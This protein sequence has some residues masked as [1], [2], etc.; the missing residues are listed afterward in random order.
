MTLWE[1]FRFE[2]AYQSRRAWTW[3]YFAVPLVVN[4]L[5]T[6]NAYGS[7]GG[8]YVLNSPLLI[9][10]FTLIA[11]VTGLLAT[12]AVA[13]E[14][15]ARD[16]QVRMYAFVYTSPVGKTSYL[17]G[18]FLAAFVPNALLMLAVQVVHLLSTVA[19]TAPQELIGPFKLIGY[20]GAYLLIGLPNAFIAT[21]LLFSLAVLSR[22][23][24]ASFVGVALLL[25]AAVI[26]YQLM[27][28]GRP[29][30]AQA[31]DPL[32]AVLFARIL[33]TIADSQSDTFSVVSY[34]PLLL[35]RLVWLGAALAVLVFTHSRFRFEHVA[36]RTW[37]RRRITDPT[38][39]AG[40]ASNL[41]RVN[42]SHSRTG[43]RRQALV[44]ADAAQDLGSKRPPHIHVRQT[45]A[46][47]IRSYRQ[48]ANSWGGLAL[49]VLAT[50]VIFFESPTLNFLVGV[51][52][53]PTTEL[54]AAAVGATG[55]AV[56]LLVRMF[57]LFHVGELIWRERETR[58]NDIADA[59][60]TPEG[61]RV[62][63]RLAGLVLVFLTFQALMLVVCVFNQAQFGYR[64]FELGLYLRILFGFQFVDYFLFLML[65]F[66]VHVVVNQK[67]FAY[68]VVVLLSAFQWMFRIYGVLL[69]IE[70]KMLVYGASPP[71]LYSDIRA[72]E[73]TVTPWMW[74]SLYW[75]GWAFLFG[76]IST[77]FWIRGRETNIL[78]RL[79]LAR[80]R[81]T[82]PILG[83]TTTAAALIFTAGGFIFYNT[84]L[85]NADASV[86]ARARQ[87]AEY[88]R[89]YGQYAQ[90]PQPQLEGM[91]LGVEIYPDRNE[92]EIRGTYRLVN[93]S[94]VA[95]DSIQVAPRFDVETS[96]ASFDRPADLILDD[97]KLS[98]RIYA[99]KT[100]LAPGEATQ[101]DFTVRF[102]PR[103]FTNEGIDPSVAANGTYFTGT[104]WLPGV[105]YQHIR[106]LADPADRRI[107]DLPPRPM[108]PSPEDAST[109][110]N[111]TENVSLSLETIVGTSQGQVAV[112]PGALLK[113]WTESGRR[114]FQYITDVP[115]R[116]DFAIY[117]AAYVVRDARWKDVLI[118]ILHHP[119]H[120]ANVERMVRG[121]QASLE[122]L[123]RTF[124]PYPHRQIRFV[125][126]PGDGDSLHSSPVNI[127][128]EEGFTRFRPESDPQD[129]S[130]PFAVVAHEVAH[131]WWGNQL[132]PARAE[133]SALLTESIAWYCA[134]R[135][136][137]EQF[138]H[139][140]LNRLLDAMRRA[141]L[142]WVIPGAPPL[143]RASDG[144]HAYRK[145]PF[146][147]YALD[148]YIGVDR[149]DAAIS[150]L[151]QKYGSGQTP[152]PTSLDLYAEFK[153]VTPDEH[154]KLL[155]DLFETNT[156][157]DLETKRATAKQTE[158]GAW[159]V[160]LDVRAHKAEVAIDGVAT[161]IPMDDM[162]EVGVFSA[163]PKNGGRGEPL[164]LR[165]H[166]IRS[167]QQDITVTVP[168]EPALA[169][170]DPRNLL[171]DIV[172]D[173]NV[174]PIAR[175]EALSQRE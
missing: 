115:I 5:I 50:A 124:G 163:T 78:A 63:G 96:A 89:L 2:I 109:S 149:V 121:V 55:R 35:H 62:A 54:Q 42:D 166:P 119:A 131:Q 155:A 73:P 162:I 168:A 129:F 70:N 143:L 34:T 13:G 45:L 48:I 47:A 9:A 49:A 67:Y 84:S 66:A 107:H 23:P 18:R 4:I 6:I 152:L 86:S 19:P 144:F 3:A 69:G 132:R 14:S 75:G 113:T 57:T 174:R 95:I 128:Y 150:R 68:T 142:L 61:V 127:S 71:W 15:A 123:T 145:G 77:V 43:A 22:R 92:V 59:V 159:E 10:V 7:Y 140:D 175:I 167:G 114:Y 76:V 125:E 122:Y 141:Y 126:R 135:I 91:T 88:E 44:A 65:A 36:S 134:M 40:E 97:K 160:T 153:A 29:L 165:M 56:W 25:V 8:H 20:L 58:M 30:L 154:R 94:A 31:L 51:P 157:W 103:G 173:D 120:S 80:S 164:Y 64:N 161:D 100:P 172:V 110:L 171:I 169:G 60:A 83:I 82:R 24:I 104:A 147:I 52:T 111:T 33:S 74:F 98:Y 46:V 17:G 1:V 137:E 28:G 139:E 170:I 151:F 108:L 37:L 117:S 158:S 39:V 133:G 105:G 38:V 32:G 11:S 27:F 87:S 26:A 85:L 130:F 53:I 21:T 156:F 101:L 102:K 106:E 116:N 81:L 118:Q 16:V 136:V 79:R 72:F 90:A 41:S 148:E 12:S 146:A 112:A 138:G 99:L 93:R